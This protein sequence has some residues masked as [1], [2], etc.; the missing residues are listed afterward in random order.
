MWLLT[1]QSAGDSF[2]TGFQDFQMD[3]LTDVRHINI[4]FNLSVKEMR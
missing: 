2:L 4:L 3:A 1:D